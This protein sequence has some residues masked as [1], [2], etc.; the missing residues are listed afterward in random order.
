MTQRVVS[1][2]KKGQ[3]TIPKDMREKHGI[4]TRAVVIDVEGGVL[5]KP[6]P[7]PSSERGSLKALFE[8]KTAKMVLAE[9]RKEDLRH[10]R[11]LLRYSKRRVR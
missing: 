8:G 3:A 1:V 9:A 10:E 4:T 7:T 11:R 2:T 5:V 6:A